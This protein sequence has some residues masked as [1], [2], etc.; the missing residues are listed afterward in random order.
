MTGRE[1]GTV[2][3]DRESAWSRCE[4]ENPFHQGELVAGIGPVHFKMT[5]D[6]GVASFSRVISTC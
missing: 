6:T 2:C 3:T 1:D 5:W 4:G